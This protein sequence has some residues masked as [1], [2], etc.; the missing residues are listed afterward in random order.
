VPEET[1]KGYPV[2]RRPF[3]VTAT[4]LLIL[5]NA[6]VWIGFAAI[7]ALDLHPA[8]PDSS[9]VR[10]V[11]GIL[12]FG[13]GCALIA[14]VVLLGKRIR[15]AYFPTLGLLALLAVLTF[16]DDVGLADWIYLLLVTTPLI[17]LVR[18]RSW[19]LKK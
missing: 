8:L 17:M 3:S 6:L 5:I 12:A 14:L 9:T 1:V 19:Y 11:M 7:V 15:I 2:K 10:W 18:D 16:T 4:F 13:C